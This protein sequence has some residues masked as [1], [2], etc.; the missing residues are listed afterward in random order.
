MY[1][2]H[3]YLWSKEEK[4]GDQINDEVQSWHHHRQLASLHCRPS[5]K[6]C[7]TCIQAIM[8]GK[9]GRLIYLQLPLSV[10]HFYKWVPRESMSL[11]YQKRLELGCPCGTLGTVR[12]PHVRLGCPY[13]N[14]HFSV[15]CKNTRGSKLCIIFKT[16]IF[17]VS[18]VIIY[19]LYPKRRK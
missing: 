11:S 19:T 1:M 13:R 10:R 5:E 15:G 12:L 4:E 7:E 3:Y 2:W 16:G 18:L 14:G 8:S 17:E 9:K 6:L